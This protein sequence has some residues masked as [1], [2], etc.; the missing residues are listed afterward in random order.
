MQLKRRMVEREGT[1]NWMEPGVS[2]AYPPGATYLEDGRCYFSVW[3]P[4]AESLAVHILGPRERFVPLEKGRHGYFYGAVGKVEPGTLYF[5]LLDGERERPDPAS[6]YQPEGVHGPSQVVDLKSFAWHDRCWSGPARE[7]LV[8]YEIHVGTFTR[9]GTFESIIPHLDELKELGI[10][11]IE[12]MPVAQFPGSRN[13]GY[14]GVYP[15]AVQNSYGGP[16]GLQRLVDACHQKELAVFLDVVYNHLGPEGNYLADYAPY[17]TERYRTPWGPAINFDG[18][19]STEV[20]RYFI[21]NALYW[22]RDFHLDGLRLDAVHA[23]MD[24]SAVH[25][26]EELAEEVH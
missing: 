1:V 17:F 3:A 10:T 13:W 9:E 21:E 4:R 18:P 20:R 12:L 6:R 24:M 2:S 15:F 26:L 23:I 22:V 16:S 5:Y 14:D 25:F 7:S 19:G 11:A 8:F